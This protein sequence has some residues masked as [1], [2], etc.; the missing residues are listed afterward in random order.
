MSS[1]EARSR[2]EALEAQVTQMTAALT[3]SDAEHVR[4]HAELQRTQQQATTHAPRNEFRLIDPRTMAPE[5]FGQ[6][7]EPSWL[8]WAENEHE[9]LYRDAGLRSSQCP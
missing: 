8:D 2:L 9:V 7:S 4:A 1:D 3:A 5:K 6:S